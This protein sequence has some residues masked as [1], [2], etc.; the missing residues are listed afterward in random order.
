[1][2]KSCLNIAVIGVGAMGQV[3]CE[4]IRDSVPELCLTAVC[5]ARSE[6]ARVAGER[7]GVPWFSDVK[8]LAASGLADVALVVVPHP[9]HDVASVPCMEAGM[10]VLCEK[11]LTESVVS[12]DKMFAAANAKGVAFGVMF[13]LRADP[14]IRRMIE[15][16]RDGGLGRIIRA[17]LSVPEFRSQ[18]Y[19]DSNP[20]RATWSG[21]G[22][23]VLLNQAP[24]MIDI[25]AMVA[26]TPVALYGRCET[27]LHDIDV[28]D[29]AEALLRFDGG[30]SGYINCS[31]TEPAGGG[32]LEVTGDNG[33]VIMRDGRV[34]IFRFPTGV[35][36][37]ARETE[38]VWGRPQQELVFE[39]ECLEEP[40]QA[41]VLQNFARHILYGEALWCD[42]ASGMAS[43]EIANAMTLSSAL[44]R[45]ISL[46][47]ERKAYGDLLASYCAK[48]ARPKRRVSMVQEPDPKFSFNKKT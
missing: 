30:G 25:F 19:F 7:F 26:G 35:S 33:R 48:P 15:F 4:T 27:R 18:Y 39:G 5:N 24:H 21:E 22:G 1:M 23:G 31:T 12:A 46:P 44:G 43:L 32:G 2:S 37:F 17:E 6:T 36:A 3:H 9:V 34:R 45:E 42:A 10:H 47:I 20:W 40:A 16:A 11:P 41:D 29:T 14:A 28:E 38:S 8:E 13:Q